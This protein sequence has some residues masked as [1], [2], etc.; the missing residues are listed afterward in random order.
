MAGDLQ[1][2]LY[3]NP[4]ADVVCVEGVTEATMTLTSLSG[5]VMKREAVAN[6]LSVADLAEGL[7]LL[8]VETAE[9]RS[10]QPIV[11]KR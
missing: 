4:A 9:G 1:V 11:V 7:Y 10:T 3:P 2:R 8:T 5:V 6:Q